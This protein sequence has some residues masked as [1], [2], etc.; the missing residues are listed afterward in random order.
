LKDTLKGKAK[1]SLPQHILFNI[2]AWQSGS[3]GAESQHFIP[4]KIVIEH[5]LLEQD[6]LTSALFGAG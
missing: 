3:Q 1:L 5:F 2:C 4:S 6:F